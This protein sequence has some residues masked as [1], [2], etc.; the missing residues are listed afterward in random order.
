MKMDGWETC[1]RCGR[2]LP[3]PAMTKHRPGG[4]CLVNIAKAVKGDHPNRMISAA[5]LETRTAQ[6]CRKNSMSHYQDRVR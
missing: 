1:E 3:A 5:E 4:V 6:Q 2:R